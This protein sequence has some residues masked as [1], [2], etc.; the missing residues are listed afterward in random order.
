MRLIINQRHRRKTSAESKIVKRSSR[1]GRL[2][3][4]PKK[5]YTENVIIHFF[6]VSLLCGLH[7]TFEM[8]A[9]TISV[10][11][12]ICLIGYFTMAFREYTATKL[13]IS[14][15]SFYFL[16]YAIA[17]GLCPAFLSLTYPLKNGLPF[18]V[19]IIELPNLAI[20]YVIFCLGSFAFHAGMALFRPAHT[21]VTYTGKHHPMIGLLTC[22]WI[23]GIIVRFVDLSFLGGLAGVLRWLPHG[24]LCSLALLPQSYIGL[25]KRTVS[26]FLVIGTLIL[27]FIELREMSKAMVMFSLIPSLWRL[28]IGG[29]IST[30]LVT[31]AA[32][33]IV[34]Y[35]VVVWPLV[36]K[37]RTY[38][39]SNEDASVIQVFRSFGKDN[40]FAETFFNEA[41]GR[42]VAI[43][44]I[45]AFSTR[46]FDPTPVGYIYQHVD[47]TGHLQGASLNYLKYA[48][49]PRLLWP[50]KP[51][52]T[53]GAW[54]TSYLGFSADEESSTTSTGI[55]ATGE[56]YWNFGLPG[57][58]LGMFGIGAGYGMLWA[59]A[60]EDPRSNPFAMLLYFMLIVKMPN[61]PEAG[62]VIV[63]I[64]ILAILFVPIIF[65]TRR[66]FDLSY[67]H[68]P[69]KRR[70]RLVKL[71]KPPK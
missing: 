1:N 18:S 27:V 12:L 60:R 16:W 5:I 10:G 42:A 64:V 41:T 9:L 47:Q 38:K 20:G 67:P 45:R 63:G 37:M 29:G 50:D 52:V 21:P 71:Q 66:Q 68:S 23:V 33:L 17:L 58:L 14:P 53:R 2:R 11:A 54:F 19:E 51:S 65:L 44:S 31:R 28:V 13:R 15:L 62:S 35:F 36:L 24:V 55:S 49:V 32:I 3:S 70:G 61:M 69:S 56:L 26:I 39:N 4:D 59:L 34:A 22:L 40:M 46:M 8:P 7:I 30:K 6:I 25:S 48:F 43:E 57:V